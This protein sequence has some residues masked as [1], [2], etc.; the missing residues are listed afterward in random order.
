MVFL[1]CVCV[2]FFFQIITSF[3]L[4]K[5]FS[6]TFY[7]CF[8]VFA[9]LG[10]CFPL[11]FGFLTDFFSSESQFFLSVKVSRKSIKSLFGISV[12]FI[13]ALLNHLNYTASKKFC[14]GYF[15]LLTRK[16]IVLITWNKLFLNLQ[17]TIMKT[18]NIPSLIYL[19]PLNLKMIRILS[20]IIAH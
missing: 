2:C 3:L 20:L 1:V 12:F 18:F 14:H 5:L 11:H 10:G 7:R 17:Q 15:L 16:K 13:N 6:K 9:S 4:Q 19:K 8:L